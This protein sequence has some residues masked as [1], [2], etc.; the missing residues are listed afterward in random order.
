VRITFVNKYYYPPHLGGIEHHLAML[1][2]A[3]AARPGVSVEAIVSNEGPET[4]RE[5]VDGVEVL[6][7]GRL[8]AYAST[9]VA[10]GMTSA[11]RAA[12]TGPA[13]ADLFHLMFPYPWGE[14]SW[15]RAGAPGP[16]V[17]AYQ[18]D[19]VRQ[20][21]LGAAYAPI[22]K[23][24]LDR[25]DRIIV[26]S[27]PMIEH[28]EALAPFAEKCRVVPL[29]IDTERFAPTPETL[30][31]AA[32]LREAHDRPVV[33]FIGRLIYYKG[34]EVLIRAMRDLDADLVLIGQ[35]PLEGDLRALCEAFG[36]GERVTFLAPVDDAEL[37]AWYRAAAVFCL[38]SVARSEAYGLVQLEAHA[39][40]TPVVST[41]LP[42]GVPW[43]NADG[44]TGLIVPVGDASA[45]ADALRRLLEDEGLRTRMGERAR[46]RALTSFTISAMVSGT[47]AVYDEVL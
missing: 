17:L 46:E 34:V 7:I 31:R 35:G 28:S 24:V 12:V 22:L 23:R 38:P 43:V 19:I 26:G 3:L 33:L 39:S 5:M 42:T 15:L 30:A 36:I 8:F 16:S 40:G 45:L 14:T 9:P 27:P 32:K 29:G 11:I 10:T 20:R 4:V 2:S 37:A 1:G 6:R 18:S 47:L 21:F 41:D 13:R 25:V 44:E